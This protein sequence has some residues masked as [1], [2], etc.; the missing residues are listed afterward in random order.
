MEARITT[1]IWDDS[2]PPPSNHMNIILW[3]GY[4]EPN[5][6]RSLLKYL[7]SAAVELRSQYLR[8]VNELGNLD[9]SGRSVVDHFSPHPEFSLWWMSLLVEKSAFKSP[10]IFDCIRILAIRKLLKETGTECLILRTKNKVLIE[11]L[12][13]LCDELSISIVIDS[14]KPHIWVQSVEKLSNK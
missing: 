7:D 1:T 13:I 14:R 4:D 5:N 11:S 9:I 2:L 3:S 10:G 8:F 6:C 12:V